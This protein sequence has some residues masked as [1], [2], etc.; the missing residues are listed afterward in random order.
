MPKRVLTGENMPKPLGPYAQAVAASGELIFISGQAGSDIRTGEIPTGFAAQ[1]RNAF[2]NLSS[3]IAAAGLSMTDVVK[4]TVYLAD[5]SEFDVLN[6]LFGEYFPAD[7]PTRATPV[8][9]LRR[10]LLISIEAVAARP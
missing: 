4:T 3:V 8:V 10:G 9:Q 6:Q 1:A 7:P 5:A 2:A